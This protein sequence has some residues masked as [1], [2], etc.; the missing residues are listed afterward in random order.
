MK[1]I[2]SVSLIAASLLTS[3][4]MTLFVAG[5]VKVNQLQKPTEVKKA[6]K[7][8]MEEPHEL[9]SSPTLEDVIRAAEGLEK[10]NQSN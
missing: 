1:I 4:L 10:S 8:K 2:F 3:V 9:G 7:C 5:C 6:V